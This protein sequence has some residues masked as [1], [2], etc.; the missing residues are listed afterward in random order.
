[1]TARRSSPGLLPAVA[2]GDNKYSRNG[3]LVDTA[4]VAHHLG[5][6]RG[7]VYEHA[8]ELGARRLGTGPKARLRF[9]LAGVDRRLTCLANRESW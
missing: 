5:T 9:D 8:D 7:Y 4:A 3:Q 1:M 6:S 2:H